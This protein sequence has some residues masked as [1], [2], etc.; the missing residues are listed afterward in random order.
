[1]NL[2]SVPAPVKAGLSRAGLLL[3]TWAGLA[4]PLPGD[5]DPGFQLD[6]SL[7]P[8]RETLAAAA[9]PDGRL[10]TVFQFSTGPELVAL[11]RD[12]SLDPDFRR[13][14]L[15]GFFP[16]RLA[17]LGDGTIVAAH[18]AGTS[19]TNDARIIRLQPDGQPT[20]GFSVSLPVAWVY[21]LAPM[22]DGALMVGAQ[23]RAVPDLQSENHL[24]QRLR[25]DGS[26]DPSFRV[27]GQ[28][29]SFGHVRRVFPSGTGY[30]VLG[31]NS[32]LRVGATG[33]R[34]E[35]FAG[36]EAS[37][38]ADLAQLPDGSFLVSKWEDGTN[39]WPSPRLLGLRR[40]GSAESTFEPIP[41]QALANAI[42]V[43]KDG[44]VL[45]AGP[46]EEV[47][48]LVR[49]GIVRVLPGGRIDPDFS[50]S[51][52]PP[53]PRFPEVRANALGELADGRI[54]VA[55]RLGRVNGTALAQP[56]AVFA[57]LTSADQPLITGLP[58]KVTVIEG[59]TLEL[60]PRLAVPA[61]SS[62][63]W[64]R[65]GI[66]LSSQPEYRRH[67][68]QLRE[69]GTIE[70]TVAWAGG[71]TTR[72]VA[73]E[74]LAGATHPGSV[75]TSF[76]VGPHHPYT[77]PNLGQSSISPPW[78]PWLCLDQADSGRIIV[79]GQFAT[80]GGESR[81]TLV[82]LHPDGR[83]D[84][85]FQFDPWL[86][87][88]LYRAMR[89][90]SAKILPDGRIF[91]LARATGFSI[92]PGGEP[93][94]G[95][96]VAFR[97]RPDG[98]LDLTYGTEGVVSLGR[99]EG[100]SVSGSDAE[101]RLVVM[102]SG[103]GQWKLARRL[104]NGAN[105]PT[106][107]SPRFLTNQSSAVLRHLA[108]QPDGSMFVGGNFTAVGGQPRAGVV[109]LRA[110]GSVD[111][112]FQPPADLGMQVSAVLPLPNGQLLVGEAPMSTFRPVLRRGLV[113]LHADGSLDPEFK[114]AGAVTQGV[115]QL[116]A[117]SAGRI[118]ALTTRAAAAE[119]QT[120]VVVRLA[121]DGTPDASFQLSLGKGFLDH[122]SVSLH[123]APDGQLLF[124]GDLW[125]PEGP[126][127]N[128]LVRINT[129]DE[130]RLEASVP[131]ADRPRLRV[132][133]RPGRAYVVE[134]S[135]GMSPARWSEVARLAGTG[136]AMEW[137]GTEGEAEGFYRVR[138]E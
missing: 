75:D 117:D 9:H 24:L 53:A 103:D 132:N 102:F 87:P 89:I 125:Q 60:V 127:R 71:T 106:F 47:G 12:G 119:E 81:S 55:G 123:L 128:T 86:K 57:R 66:T 98:S 94:F 46:F 136:G 14:S 107:R 110:D 65:G 113:R 25:P 43:L 16:G 6:P 31:G 68:V 42:T 58:E 45:M 85:R 130:M 11:K 35:T 56:L 114:V 92:S 129:S 52:E 1:M 48:G 88:G 105:D 5:L 13:Q 10:L 15:P 61:E 91:A 97:L 73:V 100:L 112:S 18:S 49:R 90:L 37:G 63:A 28:F 39:A 77:R 70:F 33:E 93:F 124:A 80:F 122:R 104:S 83:I 50:P 17:V 135:E 133:S 22:P 108:V 137:I 82:A 138:V 34:D 109:R 23:I 4:A 32:V 41:L 29:G 8:A 131:T 78:Q 40:D 2:T 76:S 120:N 67:N 134:H 121:A 126:R 3:A 96:L 30:V 79:G 20:P 21:C 99:M 118:L 38:S 101:D 74:V 115:H 36:M 95:S 84:D 62:F 116:V 54:F 26:V 44:S 64:K 51:L 111:P 7:P 69:A 72:A 59:H 19:P 27:A